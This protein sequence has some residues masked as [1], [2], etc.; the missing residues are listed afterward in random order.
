VRGPVPEKLPAISTG[1]KRRKTT[2]G[3]PSAPAGVSVSGRRRSRRA[4]PFPAASQ[5]FTSVAARRTNLSDELTFDRSDLSPDETAQVT[6]RVAQPAG[7]LPQAQ[8]APAFGVD[9]GPKC[10]ACDAL[11]TF[12]SFIGICPPCKRVRQA[13][14]SD[15][16][17][18]ASSVLRPGTSS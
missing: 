1:P 4:A 6:R 13:D 15:S 16:P 18:V 9:D 10:P 14:T 12:V 11:L 17:A 5:E 2:P 8:D 7:W 3:P